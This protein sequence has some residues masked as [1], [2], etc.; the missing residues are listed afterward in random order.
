[1]LTVIPA[2]ENFPVS[3]FGKAPELVFFSAEGIEV[4][5]VKN[6]AYQTF[7]MQE[8]QS[9]LLNKQV[10]R[11][12]VRHIEP[13]I[14]TLLLKN[15]VA[16]FMFKCCRNSI[17]ELA[18]KNDNLI[19]LTDEPEIGFVSVA[20]D[21]LMASKRTRMGRAGHSARHGFRGRCCH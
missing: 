8:L 20:S 18:K 10:S 7:N 9:L 5:R 14:L 12:L 17:G 6:P 16:V 1:M 15:N 19:A 11:V 3:H 13:Q 4:E 2:Y 21:L